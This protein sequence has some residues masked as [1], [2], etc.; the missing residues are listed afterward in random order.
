[1]LSYQRG[2][3]IQHILFLRIRKNIQERLNMFKRIKCWFKYHTYKNIRQKKLYG[4]MRYTKNGLECVQ[5]IYE[6]IGCGKIK[7][8]YGNIVIITEQE[9]LSNQR[10]NKIKNIL[11]DKHD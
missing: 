1:M 5:T 7:E 10:S 4:R 6:C 9:L 8:E 3:G 2:F 11:D